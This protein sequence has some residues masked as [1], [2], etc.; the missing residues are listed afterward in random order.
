M[1]P[2]TARTADSHDSL[3]WR[4]L[5]TGPDERRF[6]LMAALQSGELRLSEADD[7]LRLVSRLESIGGPSPLPAGAENWPQAAG[8]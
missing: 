6:V 2:F 7:V 8:R 4:L 5:D 3:V 1:F